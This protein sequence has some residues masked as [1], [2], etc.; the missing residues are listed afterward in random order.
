MAQIEYADYFPPLGQIGGPGQPWPLA[1]GTDPLDLGAHRGKDLLL[2]GEPI[3]RAS[4][5]SLGLFGPLGDPPYPDNG[6]WGWKGGRITVYVACTTPR[7]SAPDDTPAN[8]Y[9]NGRLP[10]A[11][12]FGSSLFSGVDPMSRANPAVGEVALIDPDG[13]LDYLLDYVWD[14]A[15]LTLKRG[16]RGTPFST[17]ETVARFTAAALVPDLNGKRIALRDLGWQLQGPLHGEY[18]DGSGGLNGDV[19]KAGTPKPWALGYNFNIEPVLIDAEAQIVQFHFGSSAAVLTFKHGGVELPF[20]ADYATYEL[21]RDATIPS[22]WYGTCLDHS[23]AR[24]NIGLEY[25]IRLDVIG[26]AD[27]A[28]GHP[29]PT[30]RGAIARRIATTRGV[31]R[32]DDAAQIDITAFNRVDIRH[33]APV[34]W[35]FPTPISKAEALDIVMAGI[36]GYWRIRPDGRLSIGYVTTPT[37]GTSL[38]LEYKAEGMGEP[39]KVATAPPRAGTNMSW[40]TNN[41]PQQRSELA[42]SVDDET[43]AILG[44]AARYA[45]ARSPSVATAYPTAAIVTVVNSGFWH[46]ADATLE[47]NRHQGIMCVERSRWQ[48]EMQIDPYVDLLSTV[49]TLNNFNRLGFGAAEPLLSVGIDTAGTN[50]TTFDWWG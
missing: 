32:L 25:G 20:H 15:P 34:G 14:G 8:T 5:P 35:Y 21:L 7:S 23:L 44:Q 6:E 27:V 30:T 24:A 4:G 38:A 28:Y 40:R 39:R 36:L 48:W 41:A 9:I 11:P 18:Y 31:N 3:D 22:G 17:W 47:N 29:G 45:Q 1:V 33:A 46:E 49:A 10:A 26:D 42:P 37:T 50:E 13:E 19:G 43:A 12:N 2:I 16:A